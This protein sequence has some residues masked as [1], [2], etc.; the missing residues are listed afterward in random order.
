M[1]PADN[2]KAG[3]TGKANG[4]T[5]V[6]NVTRKSD[7]P[8]VPAKSPNKAENTAAEAME[9]RGLAKGNAGQQNTSRTQCRTNDVPSA[10]ERVRQVAVRDKGARFTSI[11]HHISIDRLREA[12]NSLE[13]KAAAGVDGV[14]WDQYENNLEVKLLNL[15]SRL[16]RGAYRA[17]PSRRVY[18]PK[19]DGRKRPLGVASLEDK[20]VQRAVVEVLNA[21]FEADF[22]GFSYGFRPGRGQHNAL[23]AIA[24]GMLRKKVNWVLDADIRGFFDAVDHEWMMRFAEHRIADPRMLR[25]IRKWLGAGVLEDGKWSDNSVGTPQGATVSPLLA[26]ICL[27]YVFDLW[28]QRWR[29]Q[30]GKGDVVITR[31]ADDFIVGFQNQA[32]AIRFL[33]ELKERL[34]KF[35]LELHPDKT[36]LLRFGRYA[37]SQRAERDER[38]PETFTFLGLTHICAKSQKGGFLL[39]RQ[40][41]AKRMRA[42]LSEISTEAMRR[43]HQPIPEQGK[44]LGS[45]LRGHY[46]YYAVPTN[47]RPLCTFRTELGRV[48]YRALRRRSQRTRLT[49]Q[50]M[51][52]LQDRW[53]PPARIQHPWPEQR[54][55]ARTRGRSRVR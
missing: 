24:T 25:L 38:K 10:L 15:H 22:L 8:V 14:T 18:I 55:D 4:R 33:R 26:N 6:M 49:W 21:I 52:V 12:F 47:I 20:I 5:L 3:R 36:R 46:A 32:D 35:G 1:T 40:T 54:F 39:M 9:G 34:I 30:P 51:Q 50:R 13:K 27:H 2:G 11:F 28:V 42:K 41:N 48:W 53:L 23:D 45:V 37:A 31:Y 7:R 43:R 19:P 16:H 17:K 44:W 29:N